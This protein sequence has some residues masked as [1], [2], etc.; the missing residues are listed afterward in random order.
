[1]RTDAMQKSQIYTVMQDCV[2]SANVVLNE[3]R[4]RERYR[5]Y[6]RCTSRTETRA[7]RHTRR[8][9]YWMSLTRVSGTHLLKRLLYY[10]EYKPESLLVM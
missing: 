8:E 7:L 9:C 2:S 1:M 6:I 3:C 5:L 10:K 4:Q